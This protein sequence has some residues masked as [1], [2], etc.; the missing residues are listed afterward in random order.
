MYVI[1][2]V[3]VFG[4]FWSVGYVFIIKRFLWVLDLGVLVFKIIYW[5][6]RGIWWLVVGLGVSL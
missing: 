3:V 1:V 6:V 4:V 2:V 5:N